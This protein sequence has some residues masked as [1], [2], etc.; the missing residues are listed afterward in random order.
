MS[1]YWF[2]CAFFGQIISNNCLGDDGVIYLYQSLS[3]Q[4]QIFH[5]NLS[6]L[7]SLVLGKL[8]YVL[9]VICYSYN[10]R[11]EKR[12]LLLFSLLLI[13]QLTAYLCLD[14]HTIETLDTT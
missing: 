13:D 8:S 14:G 6:G 5:L 9:K 12:N 4:D 11:V 3:Q 1:Q 10:L 7:I 2:C